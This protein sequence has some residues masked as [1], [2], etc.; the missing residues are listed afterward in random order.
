LLVC[1]LFCLVAG[2]PVRA[3]PTVPSRLDIVLVHGAFV[4]G[5]SW[6]KVI[7]A[8]QRRGYHVTAVQ[9]PLTSLE[10]DVDATLRVIDRQPGDVMLVGHSWGG[11]VVTE[12]GNHPKVRGLVYLSALVPG[13]AESV[14][15][16]LARL[17]APMAGMSP[18]KNGMLWLDDA[19]AYAN[20]MARDV[21]R[22]ESLLLSAVQKPIAAGAFGEKVRHAAWHDKASWYLIT[23]GDRALPTPVQEKLAKQINAQ[24][25][26]LRSSHMSLVSHPGT[27]ADLIDQAA[28]SRQ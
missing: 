25:R 17:D 15:E 2:S 22:R 3:D 6:S 1:G 14:N 10:A 27:V 19:K 13:T 5:S 21:P 18:D 9:S 4:D 8:L 24:T 26:V 28:R 7:G 20:V 12:A 16:L 23:Q 11:A